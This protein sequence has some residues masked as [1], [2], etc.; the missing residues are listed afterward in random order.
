MSNLETIIDCGS[1]NIRLGVFDQSL[2][3]IYSSNATITEF[4]ENIG[5]KKS[6]NK[7][8]RDAEKKLSTHLV[9]VNL[10]YDTSKFNFIDLSIKKSFD[11]P[12][13]I[14]NHYDSLIEEANFIVSENNFKD[15]VIHIIVNNIITDGNKQIEVISEDIKIKSLILEIKFIC[16]NKSIVSIISNKFKK[17]NLNI[18]NIYCS[19]YVKSIFFK[20]NLE[21]KNNL[22]FLDIGFERTSALF[23]NNNKF[24]FLNS[25]AIGGNNITKDISKIL[26][27][28]IEYSEDLKIEFNKDENEVSFKKNSSNDINLYSEITKKN[29]SIDLLKQIIEARVNEIIELTILNNNYFKKI[30]SIEK[31]CIVFIGNGSKL[32]PNIYSINSKKTFSDLIFFEENDSKICDAGINYHRSHESYLTKN[33]KKLKKTGFFEKFFNLF[34]K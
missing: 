28:N 25:V 13:F 4:D 30:N 34:S 5:F 17:N 8:I 20:K 23:F 31:Q 11:Q 32:L 19:S 26:K 21:I 7:L 22:I 10:L 15:Q 9:N 18:T 33:K 16:L 1:K 3:K 24:Q 27:L 2:E 14:S 12:T 29:I 6:L